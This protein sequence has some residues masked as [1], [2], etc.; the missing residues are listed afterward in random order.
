MRTYLMA[1]ITAAVLV[2]CKSQSPISVSDLISQNQSE[3][4]CTSEQVLDVAT[5]VLHN[6][7]DQ[8]RFITGINSITLQGGDQRVSL[9]EC[10]GIIQMEDPPVNPHQIRYVVQST[11]DQDG[12][13]VEVFYDQRLVSAIQ[14]LRIRRQ[15]AF[16]DVPSRTASETLDVTRANRSAN[17]TGIQRREE[18]S[19][20]CQR[21]ASRVERL[22]CPDGE[23]AALDVRLAALYRNVRQDSARRSAALIGQRA[24]LSRRNQCEDRQCIVFAYRDW[25]DRI[26]QV[27]QPHSLISRWMDE[28]DR[29]RGGFGDDPETLQ[30]C[31]RRDLL[32]E[33]LTNEGWCLRFPGESWHRC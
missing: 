33:Q 25:I 31:D 32:D 28:N 11:L 17:A 2:A 4:V 26:G 9:V 21:A 5:E 30:A 23:L 12:F 14:R 18:P 22:I 3:K 8:D 16:L 27:T 10:G 6:N 29:C 24:F 7:I 13:N 19:F 1:C 15:A 20:N